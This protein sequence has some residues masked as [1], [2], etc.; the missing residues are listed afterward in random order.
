MTRRLPINSTLII[1][2]MFLVMAVASSGC[3]QKG[4]KLV[5]VSGIVTLDGVPLAHAH[6]TFSDAEG[7]GRRGASAT[8]NGDGYYSLRYSELRDGIEPGKYKVSISML[9]PELPGDLAGSKE[10]V[11]P[12]YNKNTT[13]VVEASPSGTSKANFDLVTK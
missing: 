11:P 10:K 2:W 9:S 7:A 5:R 6:V 4:P 1:A 12:Q 3:G 8:T 13:L